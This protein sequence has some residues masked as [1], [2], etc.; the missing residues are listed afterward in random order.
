HLA[1]AALCAA[2]SAFALCD[3]PHAQVDSA[4]A[5]PEAGISEALARDRSARV[6]ALRYDL[7]LTIPSDKAAPVAGRETI[8]FQLD[9]PS[10]PLAIDFDPHRANAVH[11]VEVNGDAGGRESGDRPTPVPLNGHLV[12]PSARLTRGENRVTIAFD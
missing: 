6:A 2:A 3:T 9:D 10:K 11:R 7:S 4:L 12:I 8:T 1:A 5:T